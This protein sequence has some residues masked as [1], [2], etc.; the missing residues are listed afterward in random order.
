M[1]PKKETPGRYLRRK[2]GAQ[3]G[4]ATWVLNVLVEEGHLKMKHI[5]KA[6]KI[7]AERKEELREKYRE[8]NR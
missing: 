1:K 4:D 6:A 5:K 8:Q 3:Q 2:L 7:V